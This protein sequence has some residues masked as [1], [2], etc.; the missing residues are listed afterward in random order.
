[1]TKSGPL[2][3]V[4]MATYNRADL[5]AWTIESVIHQSYKNIEFLITDNNS[6]DHTQ[7][8]LEKRKKRDQRIKTFLE[9]KPWPWAAR[10]KSL[11]HAQWEY[12][13]V[14][15]DDDYRFPDKLE[16][17]VSFMENNKEYIITGTWVVFIDKE[18]TEIWSHQSVIDDTSI[19]KR[20]LSSCKIRHPTMMVRRHKN[21]EEYRA[22]FMVWQDYEFICRQWLYGKIWNINEKLTYV[23]IDQKNSISTNKYLKQRLTGLK[24]YWMYRKH[25]PNRLLCLLLNISLILIPR[26]IAKRISALLWK[27]REWKTC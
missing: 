22:D 13:A 7:K 26:R 24:I 1:M 10:N 11:Q 21:M 16:K 17:Q 8:V 6:T 19:R 3:S 27:R 9:V 2:I 23:T 14:I 25:Y 20:I 12:I 18:H 5:V 15:D 4:I